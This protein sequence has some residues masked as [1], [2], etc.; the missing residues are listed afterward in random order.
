VNVGTNPEALFLILFVR[1]RKL[2]ILRHIY[3]VFDV[4]H[5]RRKNHEVI[6]DDTSYRK[7]TLPMHLY[8]IVCARQA[9]I[10]RPFHVVC[11]KCRGQ[12]NS[13]TCLWR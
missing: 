3:D 9:F 7:G 5:G 11:V 12:N 2:K 13:E 4:R 10:R 1:Q 8:G 6:Y